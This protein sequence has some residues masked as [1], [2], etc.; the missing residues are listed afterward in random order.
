[1]DTVHNVLSSNAETVRPL[2]HDREWINMV[3]VNGKQ[4]RAN[5]NEWQKL[6]KN[7]AVRR[8]L[9]NPRTSATIQKWKQ[10]LSTKKHPP[11]D[12]N[13]LPKHHTKPVRL[14][15]FPTEILFEIFSHVSGPPPDEPFPLYR[16][17][18]PSYENESYRYLVD[19]LIVNKTFYSVAIRLLYLPS[20]VP[21][22]LVPSEWLSGP[23]LEA[24][25]RN[26]HKPYCQVSWTKLTLLHYSAIRGY[27][28]TIRNVLEITKLDINA[29]DTAY[30]TALEYAIRISAPEIVA[31]LVSLGA[32]ITKPSKTE[33]VIHVSRPFLDTYVSEQ[34]YRSMTPLHLAVL[35]GNKR[36]VATLIDAGA[37]TSAV[38]TRV[39]Y[40]DPYEPWSMEAPRGYP[41]S[42]F[43]NNLGRRYTSCCKWPSWLTPLALGAAVNNV[44]AVS[45]LVATATQ[46]V[47]NQAMMMAV[48]QCSLGSFDILKYWIRH[49]VT[50]ACGAGLLH[51][52]AYVDS[53]ECGSLVKSLVYMGAKVD[54]ENGMGQT[55]LKVALY[56]GNSVV[57]KTLV[58]AGADTSYN[59]VQNWLEL[60][61]ARELARPRFRRE[62]RRPDVCMPVTVDTFPGAGDHA[63]H[64]KRDEIALY[65]RNFVS[66]KSSGVKVKE[67]WD[68]LDV[69]N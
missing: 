46:K 19:L 65:M 31:L 23:C 52:A 38:A 30:T 11:A 13:Y 63:F 56:R 59:R 27:S 12:I 64:V 39:V 10:K 35:Y 7:G 58:E 8:I 67:W 24:P 49:D 55:P 50:H 53:E 45:L 17:S 62:D 57:V 41:G 60:E 20:R 34:L 32:S 4:A 6:K 26:F 36:K 37:N 43:L 14:L 48:A 18:L 40:A 3:S 25:I 42:P 47:R 66:R 68:G 16:P 2:T 28:T 5:G 69:D 22:V 29:V 9:D 15:D 21:S 44:D 51:I 1:M 33:T 54:A 61:K